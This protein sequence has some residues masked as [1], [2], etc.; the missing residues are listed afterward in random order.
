[1]RV[2]ARLFAVLREKAGT[3]EVLLEVEEGSTASRAAA[4]LLQRFPQLRPFA[5]AVLL[6]VN[7][8]YVAGAAGGPR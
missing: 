5:G 8:C 2:T 3:S 1:M 7:A 4:L 6:A